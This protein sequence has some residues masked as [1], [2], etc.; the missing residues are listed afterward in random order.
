MRDFHYLHD[1]RVHP[2]HRGS[3][4]YRCLLECV[5]EDAGRRAGWAFATILDSNSRTDLLVRGCGLLPDARPIGR[6]VHFGAPLF[7]HLPGHAHRVVR[8]TAEEAWPAYRSL[9]CTIDFAPA[10]EAR[11]RDGEGFFLGLEVTGRI[12]AVAK[13][14]DQSAIRKLVLTRPLPLALRVID[15]WCRWRGRA[16]LPRLGE[17]FRHAYL[18]FCVGEPGID[19]RGAF[20]AHLSRAHDHDYA[21]AFMGLSEEEAPARRQFMDVALSST[22][23]AYGDAPAGVVFSF[24]ELTLV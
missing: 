14:V 16:N 10:D 17:A 20:L 11:F 12:V 8:L 22:T 13:V 4:I 2:E 5:F 18:G 7:R 3:G 21:Y 15:P 6:T 9:A 23:Y 1:V 24:R 19:H